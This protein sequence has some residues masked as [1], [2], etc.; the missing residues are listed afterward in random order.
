MAAKKRELLPQVVS[1][2]YE[3]QPRED[4][5]RDHLG[6][7]IIGH[8]C[9]RFLWLTF[10]WALDPKHSGQQ[11]RLFSRGDVEERRILEELR[12]G[13]AIL[14]DPVPFTFG[15]PLIGGSC[16]GIGTIPGVPG[17]VV[18]ECKTH[19]LNS[20]ARLK[21]KGVRSAKPQHYVQM[22]AYMH[23]TGCANA[24]YVAVCKDNDEIHAELV[25]YDKARAEL[26][27]QRARMMVERQT[28]PD[29]M[30]REFP[31]CVYTSRDGTQWKCDFY[32]LCHG[33][34]VPDR[35][36][37]TCLECTV[38]LTGLSCDLDNA[39]LDPAAQRKGCARQVSIPAI[40]SALWTV[41]DVDETTRTIT[42]QHADGRID[43]EGGTCSA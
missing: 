15:S 6:A 11:L 2:I 31:P 3:A 28:P 10:R 33:D 30:D 8:E 37:R 16:D 34:A 20:F 13:G 19:S 29:V 12:R 43:R 27:I 23:G 5:R 36:C 32:E 9:D 35:S 26:E 21:E 24:V 4:W 42:Y 1:L 40:R 22:Q 18:I 14:E 25:P 7:S 41:A 39:P 17:R 38:T